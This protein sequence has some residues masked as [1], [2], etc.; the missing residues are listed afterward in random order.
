MEPASALIGIISG[1]VGLLAVAAQVIT[2]LQALRDTYRA[3][4]ILVLDLL[5][6]CNSYELAWTKLRDWATMIEQDETSDPSSEGLHEVCKLADIGKVVLE[7]IKTDLDGLALLRGRRGSW[8]RSGSKLTGADAAT[9]LLHEK[10]VRDHCNTLNHQICSLNIL[11]S[12][13]N[14]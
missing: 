10:A 12:I 14:M 9:L 11:I 13:L 4:N 3:S 5:V 1:T 2:C 6:S 8:W 7:T